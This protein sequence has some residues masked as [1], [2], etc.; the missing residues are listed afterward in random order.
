MLEDAS[1]SLVFILM[2][3]LVHLKTSCRESTAVHK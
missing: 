3:D 2:G 1:V